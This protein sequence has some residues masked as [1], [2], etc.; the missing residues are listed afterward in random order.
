MSVAWT[1]VAIVIG[2]LPGIFFTAGLFAHERQPR[3][4]VRA[5]AIGEIALAVFVSLLVHL[6]ALLALRC[7]RVDL[8][9]FLQPFLASV[10]PER[11]A[12]FAVERAPAVASYALA[13][14]VAGYLSGLLASFAFTRFLPGTFLTH[15]WIYQL[16]EA[17][18]VNAYVLTKTT[19]Q[20]RFVLYKGILRNYYFKADGTFAYV[21]LTSVYRSF[22]HMTGD[23]PTTGSL[24]EFAGPDEGD[25]SRLL[26]ISGESIANIVLDT[27]PGLPDK[28]DEEIER[29]LRELDLPETVDERHPP[30]PAG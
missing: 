18:A 16:N 24:K 11:I 21:V 8:E 19:A 20:D 1:T 7:F 25:V 12:H 22:L 17:G 14:A 5:S 29:I 6:A 10:P 9:R 23:Y 26:I 4:I 28:A 15:D 30:P 13:T 27:S 2:L 3:E